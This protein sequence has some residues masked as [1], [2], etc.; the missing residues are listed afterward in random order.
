MGIF[1]KAKLERADFIKDGVLLGLIEEH[2]KRCSYSRIESYIKNIEEQGETVLEKILDIIK[3]DHQI[4]PF[5]SRK[6]GLP[7][8]QMN[9][10]FG[11]PL[12]E[13]ITMFGLQVLKEIDGSFLL[14]I[15]S[16]QGRAYLKEEG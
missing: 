2:E 4:R 7:P 12:T 16:R 5:V 6:L 15:K 10:F 9:L 8:N 3:F 11:R 1:K 14:T 13:T